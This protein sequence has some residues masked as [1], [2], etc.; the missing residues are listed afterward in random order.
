MSMAS[1]P[2][3]Q[4]DPEY[5]SFPRERRGLDYSLNWSLADDMVTPRGD[6][7]RN[8]DVLEL[9]MHSKGQVDA[10][11][12]LHV[13]FQPAKVAHAMTDEVAGVD[14]MDIDAYET[15]LG[16]VRD[17]LSTA[18]NL[19]VHDGAVG[20]HRS[21]EVRV[22]VIT[23]SAD[24]ALF[25][26]NVLNT[27]P[28]GHPDAFQRP[29]VVYALTNT[30]MPAAL[31]SDVDPDALKATVVSVGT[32]DFASLQDA[33]AATVG[34]VL[35]NPDVL[36]APSGGPLM[37]AAR[38]DGLLGDY[39][40]V[41]DSGVH[42]PSG[43]V[44]MLPA[45]A[46]IGKD[47]STSLVVGSTGLSATAVADG[48]LFAARHSVW[49]PAGVC[50]AWNAVTLP[51]SDVPGGVPRGSV[52]AGSDATVAVVG[53][54][55]AGAPK[56]VVVVGGKGKG[57]DAVLGAV[58]MEEAA[59]ETLKSQLDASGTEVVTVSNDKGLKKALA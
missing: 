37:Q 46:V 5:I 53:D 38:R 9:L 30:S 33:I 21:G 10:A 7:F 28:I 2:L 1:F 42:V 56:R 31:A 52:V 59:A 11:R 29:I 12:A 17:G 27:V 57:L 58:P 43:P 26:R 4:E 19:F 41:K 14:V 54:L 20:S 6:A 16:S 23:D 8:A 48:S 24:Y 15:L 3:T 35:A 49:G 32:P 22:R 34:Q 51:A 39:Y 50:R 18:D 25:F 47:G 13:P 45:D 55:L 36:S 44:S 40:G